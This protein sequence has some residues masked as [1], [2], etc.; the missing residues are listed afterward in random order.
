M[1]FVVVAPPL[2]LPRAAAL[3]PTRDGSDVGNGVEEDEEDDEGE[4]EG[5]EEE[6]EGEEDEEVEDGKDVGS[7][8]MS[9]LIWLKEQRLR[10]L[11]V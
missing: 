9:D 11:R 8:G 4:E 1:L 10:T 2:S 5:K 6:E 7:S 3:P